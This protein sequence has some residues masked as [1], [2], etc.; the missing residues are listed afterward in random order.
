MP[1]IQLNMGHQFTDIFKT[2]NRIISQTGG[3]WHIKLYTVTF[4]WN[5][6]TWTKSGECIFVLGVLFYDFVSMIF[7]IDFI[8][9]P[10]VLLFFSFFFSFCLVFHFIYELKFLHF[11]RLCVPLAFLVS[12]Q[13]VM[14]CFRQSNQ[15]HRWCSFQRSRL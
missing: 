4:Y 2:Y 8:T 3:Y 13:L 11:F 6:C 12:I 14:F 15:L 9:V 5:V 1:L 10:T 7:S